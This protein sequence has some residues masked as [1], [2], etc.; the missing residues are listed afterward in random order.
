MQFK[1]SCCIQS[2]CFI[3]R[4]TIKIFKQHTIQICSR[5]KGPRYLGLYKPTRPRPA[6]LAD[7]IFAFSPPSIRLHST[8]LPWR[9]RRFSA[10]PPAR[11]A[12]GSPC[13]SSR[14]PAGTARH[15]RG[16]EPQHPPPQQLRAHRGN[17]SPPVVPSGVSTGKGPCQGGRSGELTHGFLDW[18]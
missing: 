7:V 16:P 6:G 2:K 1:S 4:G 9:R 13:W 15:R 14:V 3:L 12:S 5:R 10:P 8:S 11:S 18:G 17:Q